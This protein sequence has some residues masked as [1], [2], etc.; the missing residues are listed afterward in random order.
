METNCGKATLSPVWLPATCDIFALTTT[1]AMCIP[2]GELAP[3]ALPVADA[4]CGPPD[5]SEGVPFG[6]E[7]TWAPAK[8]PPLMIAVQGATA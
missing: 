4:H 5:K 8:Q 3:N 6:R 1:C 2:F 7:N